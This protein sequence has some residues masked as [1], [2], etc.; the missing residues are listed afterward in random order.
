MLEQ[1]DSSQG[2]QC[3]VEKWWSVVEVVQALICSAQL[4]VAMQAGTSTMR[5][6]A[7]RCRRSTTL[8]ID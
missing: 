2:G 8:A 5:R 6:P 3:V 4:T 7:I 1:L